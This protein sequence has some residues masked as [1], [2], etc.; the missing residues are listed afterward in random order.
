M[1]KDSVVKNCL[2]KVLK[3]HDGENLGK[4]IVVQGG[5]MRN[6][7]VVRAFE[8]LTNTEVAR[9]NMPELMGAYGCALHA[10]E[11]FASA[12]DSTDAATKHRSID[13]LLALAHNDTRQLQCHGCENNCY[14]SC[15]T[16][17]GGNKYYS[18]NKCERVFNNHGCDN[19]KGENIP[20]LWNAR[21]TKEKLPLQS[22]YHI[23]C[24]GSNTTSSRTC[25]ITSG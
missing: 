16:F 17:A 19:A 2:Y 12:D 24:R 4:K 5:T 10:A 15:H 6:D 22:L 21:F 25:H 1:N 18:G 11:K 9:S 23:L 8:L 14:V 7:A 13:A 3:L 20:Q